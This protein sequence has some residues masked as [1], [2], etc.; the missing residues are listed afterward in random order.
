MFRRRSRPATAVSSK[1]TVAASIDVVDDRN[2]EAMTAGRPT[3]VDLW[4]PW[5]GPCRTFRPIFEAVAAQRGDD[6]RFGSCNVEENPNVAMLLQVQSIPTVVAF[7][8]DGSEVG[9]LVGLPSRSRFEAF[10][11]DVAA[12]RQRTR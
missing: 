8:I 7:G 4:A 2:F 11:A 12:D 6:V 10:V 1:S 5:C 9:R 3:V